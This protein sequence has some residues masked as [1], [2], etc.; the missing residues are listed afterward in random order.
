MVKDKVNFD[1][2]RDDYQTKHP[3]YQIQIWP[4]GAESA[5]AAKL[6]RFRSLPTS[7][8]EGDCQCGQISL[9]DWGPFQ[10]FSLIDFE[11][12]DEGWR[13]GGVAGQKSFQ[14]IFSFVTDL[15]CSL[16]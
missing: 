15:L 9:S 4:G 13:V 6:D 10:F 3:K 7:G 2:F 11:T 1:P 14:K 5:E 16:I 8:G 12:F